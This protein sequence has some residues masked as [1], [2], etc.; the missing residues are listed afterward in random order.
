VRQC[1][2][3][4]AVNKH[5][6]VLTTSQCKPSEANS[7]GAGLPPQR[8]KD[9]SPFDLTIVLKDLQPRAAPVLVVQDQDQCS[10][11]NKGVKSG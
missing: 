11:T 2:G 8:Y 9:R 6:R 7:P 5:G 1:R 3:M 10:A 4:H